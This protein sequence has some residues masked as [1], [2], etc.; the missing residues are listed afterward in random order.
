MLNP[1]A[2]QNSQGRIIRKLNDKATEMIY[3]QTTAEINV[4][5]LNNQNYKG[6]NTPF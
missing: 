2:Y 1:K 3:V 6:Q 5:E 4:S